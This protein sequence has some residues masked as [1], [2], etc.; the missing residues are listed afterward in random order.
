MTKKLHYG[1]IVCIG[2]TFFMLCCS[3]MVIN[4]FSAY[5]P[6]LVEKYGLSQ[7]QASM[8]TTIRSF[9]SLIFKFIVLWFIK[10]LGVRR[11]MLIGGCFT[12]ASFLT[13]SFGS[14][15]ASI[16]AAA[17][18][19]GAGYGMATMVPISIVL[20]SWFESKL[21]I[22]VAVCAANTGVSAMVFPTMITN[23]VEKIGLSATFLGQS[24]LILVLC[25]LATL[26]I[27]NTPSE[28]GLAPFGHGSE[29]E[30]KKAKRARLLTNIELTGF[31]K[32]VFLLAPLLLGAVTITVPSLFTLHFTALG[33][34]K[35]TAAMGVSAYGF[36]MLI[37]KFAYGLSDDL[38][39]NTKTN[40]LFLVILTA[41]CLIGCFA[42][43]SVPIMILST[44]LIG[45][46]CALMTVGVTMW[47]KDFSS[48]DGYAETVR[49]YQILTMVGTLIAAPISGMIADSVG[50]YVPVFAMFAVM[51]AGMLVV[52]MSGYSAGAK[53]LKSSAMQ[54]TEA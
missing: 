19:T 16:Y 42:A 6:F 18:L 10:R 47:A 13:Y 24:I 49:L 43:G 17:A 39:G 29:E 38:I 32:Y 46:G 4:A 34:D 48:K 20:N 27:R 41:G 28:M 30:T 52:I 45:L 54:Q 33:F 31:H 15:V 37:G 5:L 40:Y 12:V 44:G 7:T 23:F 53:Q 36:T 14:S 8:I 9:A 26:L 2:C 22:A 25:L 11:T 50:N 21:A 3:G 1:W 51:S 35:M